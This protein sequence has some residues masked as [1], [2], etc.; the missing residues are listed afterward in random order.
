MDKVSIIVP[1][2]NAEATIEHCVQSILGQT[3]AEFELLLMD[4]GSTDR[5]WEIICQLAAEDNR[6]IPVHKENTGVSDTRNQA[7]DRAAG[8]YVQ[9]IDADDWIEPDAT[10]KLVR[11]MEDNPGCDMVISDFKRVI[12]DRIDVKGDIDDEKLITRMEYA[13]AMMRNPADFYYGVLWNKFYRRSIIEDSHLRMDAKLDW[14]EDFIFNMEYVLHTDH[15]YVLKAPIYYYVRTKGSLVAQGGASVAKTVRM[16]LNVIEYYSSFYKDIYTAGSYY[17][18]SPVIYSFL[19][20]FA[21]DGGVPVLGDQKLGQSRMDVRFSPKMEDNPFVTT[22]YEDRLLESALNRIVNGTELDE[23]DVQV[24]LYLRL[25]GG[26]ASVS[27]IRNYTGLSSRSVSGSVQKLIR[28]KYIEKVPVPRKKQDRSG[29][30]RKNR[31]TAA[32]MTG[33]KRIQQEPEANREKPKGAKKEKPE[34]AEKPPVLIRFGEDS[35]DILQAL[36][37]TFRDVD[38]LLMRN[39]SEEDKETYQRLSGAAAQ[40][41]RKALAERISGV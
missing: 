39:F 13:Q 8:E 18:R 10:R 5:T 36:N 32:S 3:Y 2:Y 1:A 7:L 40:N 4:D 25:A 27:E 35:S 38:E 34:K 29:R 20:N 16:K 14:A 26:T 31:T 28:R 15:I 37:R 12:G 11:A 33:V 21:T 6:I 41:V 23:K 22:Y 24:L 17:L 19:L 9:F 30:G